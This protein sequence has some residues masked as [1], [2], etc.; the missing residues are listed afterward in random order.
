[1][2]NSD[3]GTRID[4]SEGP[5]RILLVA[6]N[7]F[8]GGA[9][10]AVRN[11][12]KLILTN[13]GEY[14][15]SSTLWVIESE[16]P[17]P[18][19]IVGFPGGR[20]NQWWTSLLASL[21]RAFCKLF[22]ERDGQ[23]R[24]LAWVRTGVGSAINKMDVD[25][26]LF[27]WLG[28]A[29]ISIEELG[30]VKAPK[31]LILHD[32]WAIGGPAHFLPVQPGHSRQLPWT[33]RLEASLARWMLGRKEA[34]WT[35][36]LGVVS[37]THDLA[38]KV[39]ESSIFREGGVKVVPNCVDWEFWCPGQVDQDEMPLPVDHSLPIVVFVAAGGIQDRRKGYDFLVESLSEQPA[40]ANIQLIVVGSTREVEYFQWGHTLPVGRLDQ[41]GMRSVYRMADV[42]ALPSTQE[43]QPMVALEAL[44][45]GTSV[46]AMGGFDTQGAVLRG[47]ARFLSADLGPEAFG[48]LLFQVAQAQTSLRPQSE[49]YSR[50]AADAV[51]HYF[52]RLSFLH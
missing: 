11:L 22:L 20:W 25:V 6:Q 52:G 14:G 15:I 19:T 16:N 48:S 7:D 41:V 1:V 43:I 4:K 40:G 38:G 27:G 39:R 51:K 30:G 10:A 9:G 31:F 29:T 44:A 36:E 3:P 8:K 24:S 35:D 50:D 33:A 42:V 13:G 26:V 45:C 37:P 21:S 23:I 17:L 34:S 2:K 47:G 49:N 46:V 5:I 12:H 28:D 18:K 32:E